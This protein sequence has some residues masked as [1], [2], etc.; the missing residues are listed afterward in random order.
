MKTIRLFFSVLCL[1]AAFQGANLMAQPGF[2][3]YVFT[4]NVGK[5]GIT[6]AE[7]QADPKAFRARYFPK[8]GI[9][10]RR[11][12]YFG[13]WNWYNH[14]AYP[15]KKI[16]DNNRDKRT[17]FFCST[18]GSECGH[19]GVD[20]LVSF[21]NYGANEVINPFPYGA[22][23]VVTSLRND[24]PDDYSNNSLGNYVQLTCFLDGNANNNDSVNKLKVTL[25]H[26]K[27]GSVSVRMGDFVYPGQ[28]LGQIGYSGATSFNVTHAHVTYEHKGIKLDPFKGWQNPD[29]NESMLY[30]QYWI[31]HI[32]NYQVRENDKHLTLNNQFYVRM[33]NKRTNVYTFRANYPIAAI[34]VMDQYGNIIPDLDVLDNPNLQ[35]VTY[36]TYTYPGDDGSNWTVHEVSFRWYQDAHPSVLN[37][38]MPF[39]IET[40]HGELSNRVFVEVY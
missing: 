5:N 20:W 36:N 31:E 35:N 29:L 28:P 13:I 38:E 18:R 21:R 15:Y 12:D 26:L 24:H 19:N 40:D 10:V 33:P 8:L 3:N 2:E 6:E 7:Y 32:T 16:Y 22:T 34:R 9:P 17:Y 1:I 11:E 14:G 27:Q 25:S 39:L 4:P 30:N 23:A 37:K